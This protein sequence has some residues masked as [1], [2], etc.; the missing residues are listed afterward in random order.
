MKN[1]KHIPWIKKCIQL[2][3][4]GSGLVSPNPLVGC[5]IVKA[6]RQ[7][8]SGFHPYFGGPHAEAIALKKAGKRARGATLYVSLEPCSTTGK[9][10]PCTEAIVN[11][12]IKQVVF[13]LK[14]P[15]PAHFN[16]T[17]RILS[18]AKIKIVSGV[19]AEEVKKQNE[20]FCVYHEKKRPFI[21]LKMAQSIDGKITNAKNG[22]QTI[23][24][25]PSRVLTHFFRK[26][27]DAVLV[28]TQTVVA[29]NP[30]LTTY[31]IKGDFVDN[32]YRIVLDRNL[33]LKK[34]LNIFKSDALT[35]VLTSNKHSSKKVATYSN[36]RKV[37]VFQVK[38][39]NG[40]L[41][42]KK[43][44][45]VLYELGISSLLVEGGGE[46]AASFLKAK[47]VDKAYF[48]ISPVI[49]GG[50]STTTSVEGDGFDL[51]KNKVTLKD[52]NYFDVGSDLLA[53]GYL[54]Y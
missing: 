46:V 14:D 40:V 42:I 50:R 11:S 28:G 39:K 9:T 54:Q 25:L 19:L 33:Q 7:I 2:A 21:T 18:K 3:E 32:P 41:D 27:A 5:V 35:A 8:S 45:D 1:S 4:K 53:E 36:L 37:D 51:L 13:G 44:L 48:F 17:T 30:K 15:N 49:L 31:L 20:S 10:S 12:G 34:N 47:A 23:S 29:D 22:R 52:L 38:E 6:G 24:S 16:K 43:V 26:Q